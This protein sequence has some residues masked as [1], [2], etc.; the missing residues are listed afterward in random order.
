MRRLLL[1]ATLV[2]W[3][4]GGA[5]LAGGSKTAYWEGKRLPSLYAHKDHWV[6]TSS[7]P[8]RTTLKNKVVLITFTFLKCPHART[9]LPKMEIWRERWGG[10]GLKVIEID[11]G[12]KDTKEKV[13]EYTR[14]LRK[15][16]PVLWDEKG[17]FTEKFRVTSSPTCVL[18][19]PDGIVVWQGSAS[20]F[21][22][23][24]DQALEKQMEALANRPKAGDGQAA[25]E[26]KWL[27]EKEAFKAAREDGKRVLLLR[28]SPASAT[29]KSLHATLCEEKTLELLASEFHCVVADHSKFGRKKR[30]PMLWKLSELW[31][32]KCFLWVFSPDKKTKVKI[33]A[34]KEGKPIDA[35]EL[36][37]RLSAAARKPDPG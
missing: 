26:P 3:C 27:T 36:R 28:Y 15:K 8:S 1:I 22:K 30:E 35:A 25:A 32:K 2:A 9:F 14:M 7:P 34:R 37:K 16:H 21:F 11:D 31:D 29:S 23:S 13:E 24:L 33:D 20:R 10:K 5:A 12:R 6:N 4:C 17:K 18:A 19:G